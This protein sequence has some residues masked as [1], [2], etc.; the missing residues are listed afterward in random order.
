MPNQCEQI[1]QEY[2]DL[3]ILKQKF[4]LECKKAVETKSWDK[5]KELQ[6]ELE[7]K[8]DALQN[9]VWPFEGLLQKEAK[10]QYEK[11]ISGYR[12]FG[13]LKTLAS[14]Q[15][16][17]IGENGQEYPVPSFRE[18][19]KAL[20]ANQEFFAEKFAIMENPRIHLTPF[21]LSPSAMADGYGR[22][23]EDH[24]AEAKADGNARIP[25]KHKTKLFGVDG[26][27]LELRAD[28]QNIYFADLLKDLRY[29]P[30]WQKKKGAVEASGGM[31]KEETITKL[32]GWQII[33]IED[34]PLAPIESQGKPME[35]EI[36]I[37]GKTKKVKRTQVAGGL[38]AAEQYEHFKRQNETGFT[39]EDWISFARLRLK[40]K[41]IVLDD[42][43]GTNYYCRLLGA[44]TADGYVPDAYWYRGNRRAGLGGHNPGASDSDNVAR[45]AVRVE[46]L[47]FKP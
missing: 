4:D 38:N 39:P 10:E 26:E 15:E 20:M 9:K 22:Q 14:G 16:G 34:V 24:F 12:E 2:G 7:Q 41:N 29:F 35:K 30:E 17:I 40:E 42:D 37:K 25:D 8:I 3:K 28:K 1:K 46:I 45:G 19:Q 44:K 11:A 43:E 32:G 6:A 31:T 47:K 23:I 5:A 18:I 21:A 13:W 27:P 36:K 33:I